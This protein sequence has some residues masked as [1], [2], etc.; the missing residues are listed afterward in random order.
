MSINNIKMLHKPPNQK[1][2][3]TNVNAILNKRS[4]ST[5]I[6][7]LKPMRITK[8]YKTQSYNNLYDEI[9]KKKKNVK[10]DISV[11][12]KYN[13]IYAE[14]E[15]QFEVKFSKLNLTQLQR[16]EKIQK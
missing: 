14:N 13:L 10:Q 1:L 5:I 9:F 3:L 8:R 12:N 4:N 7:E 11:N 2:L 6:N 15:K 16:R